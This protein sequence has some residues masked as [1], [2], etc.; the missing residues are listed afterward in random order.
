[1]ATTHQFDDKKANFKVLLSTAFGAV[2]REVDCRVVL[3]IHSV[4][5]LPVLD[6]AYR[7]R[8]KFRDVD[9]KAAR[10]QRD[11]DRKGHG[12]NN[13]TSSKP[14]SY[15][16]GDTSH[17][18]VAAASSSS[19]AAVGGKSNLTNISPEERGATPY[20]NL[21]ARDHSVTFE[22]T[23]E[24]IAHMRVIK[25]ELIGEPLKLVI[26]R[27]TDENED[28]GSMKF[29]P[30][31]GHKFIDLA[32]F[33]NEGKIRRKY[34]LERSK[35]NAMVTISL[36]ITTLKSGTDFKKPD[37]RQDHL[38]IGR[39][40]AM[41]PPK[42]DRPLTP[43]NTSPNA[44]RGDSVHPG[45]TRAS[46]VTSS[47]SSRGHS[48]RGSVALPPTRSETEAVIEALF[49]PTIFTSKPMT[50]SRLSH[51]EVP[52][53]QAGRASKG[54]DA[55]TPRPRDA[56]SDKNSLDSSDS[57]EDDE[58]DEDNRP[59]SERS[60]PRSRR[61]G[62]ASNRS[63]SAERSSRR[64][65]LGNHQPK[66]ALDVALDMNHALDHNQTVRPR[67]S[68]HNRTTSSGGPE[69]SWEFVSFKDGSQGVKRKPT[70]DHHPER[71][72][73]GD[74]TATDFSTTSSKSHVSNTSTSSGVLSAY[75][76]SPELISSQSSGGS[77][78]RFQYQ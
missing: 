13:A 29:E 33:V 46:S 11:L 18:D 23:V 17:S 40:E 3:T 27:L 76:A 62:A 65:S 66:T 61:S 37:L 47:T 16:S 58:E 38:L 48:Y 39:K 57:D 9:A 75:R 69:G 32:E 19:S 36:E 68:N 41:S 5:N 64:P 42:R 7:V 60:K 77:F 45:L 51:M 4:T 72:G 56:A 10:Q 1:M 25:G 2:K 26:E 35:T 31:V 8:W 63:P 6:G 59:Q 30:R 20:R 74:S 55:L 12:D 78:G 50:P 71:S 15:A 34:L 44:L 28:S 54:D 73:T 53:A 52:Q 24:V 49:N 22:S 43:L 67:F 70:R 14:S 21:Q